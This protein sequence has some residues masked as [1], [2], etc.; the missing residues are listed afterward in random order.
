MLAPGA[1]VFPARPAE[2]H[3]NAGGARH[4]GRIGGIPLPTTAGCISIIT[5]PECIRQDCRAPETRDTGGK[6][7]CCLDRALL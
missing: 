1:P 4:R 7:W 5:M 3:A 2:E 6:R